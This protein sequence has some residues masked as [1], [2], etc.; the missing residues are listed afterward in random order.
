MLWPAVVRAGMVAISRSITR[1]FQPVRRAK[2]PYQAGKNL[3]PA[4]IR[5]STGH[6][7]FGFR[8]YDFLHEPRRPGDDLY[9]SVGTPDFWAAEAAGNRPP[10]WPHPGG[11]QAGK[12]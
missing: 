8:W 1:Y 4:L 12:Q 3:P 9:L 11:V 10:V 2:G 7:G 5:C 6:S